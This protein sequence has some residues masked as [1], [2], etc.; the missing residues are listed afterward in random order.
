MKI[1]DL[2][3]LVLVLGMVVSTGVLVVFASSGIGDIKNITSESSSEELMATAGKNLQAVALGIRNSLD[4]QMKKEY[5]MVRGWAMDP[6]VIETAKQASYY[7]G[8]QLTEMWSDGKWENDLSPSLSKYFARLTAASDFS[9][10]I[11]TDSRGYLIASSGTTGTFDHSQAEWYQA[12]L[13]DK[14]LVHKSDVIW[15]DGTKTCK[16]EITSQLKDDSN[17]YVGQI[18]GVYTYSS[19]IKQFEDILTLQVYEVK[20]VDSKGTVLT[21]SHTDK[22]KVN[23]SDY[24][25]SSDIAFTNAMIYL[26]GFVTDGYVDENNETV[27]AGYA[28]SIDVNNH[29]VMVTKKLA[30]V[31]APINTF[32]GTLQTAIGDKSAVLQRNM[33]I[34][35][36]AVAIVLLIVAYLIIRAKVSVPLKKLTVISDKLAN[37]EIEGLDINVHGKDEIS[38]FGEHFKG[39]LAAFNFLKEE[40]ETKN[41]AGVK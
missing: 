21:T 24:N 9:E 38:S 37:G 41:K 32:L 29:V 31:E 19:L 27:C 23:N 36:A 4:S 25:V 35:G 40:A 17:T 28:K 7:T 13:A 14:N 5:E 11:L 16:L 10:I 34:I 12:T 22:T 3:L 39:V 6:F 33:I 1:R 8:S 20:V 30:G 26:N 2:I 18:K 15:D